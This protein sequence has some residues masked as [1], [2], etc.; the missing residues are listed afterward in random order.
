MPAVRHGELAQP[1]VVQ[2]PHERHLPAAEGPGLDG[3]PPRRHRFV[4]ADAGGEMHQPESSLD[5]GPRT[6]SEREPAQLNNLLEA[7]GVVEGVNKASNVA[8]GIE[9]EADDPKRL[10]AG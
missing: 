6:R 5:A 2:V 4:V 8:G 7:I 1:F 3:D 9:V 10:D